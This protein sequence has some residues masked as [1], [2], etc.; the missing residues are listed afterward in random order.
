M[1][2]DV[3]DPDP[4]QGVLV[5]E[6]SDFLIRR[7]FG[8]R[9]VRQG[10]QNEIA[11][12]QPS[13]GQLTRH[14]RMSKNLTSF[15]EGG[16]LPVACAQMIDPD[17]RIDQDHGRVVGR[18]RGVTFNLASVP[19]SRANRRALSRSISALSASRTRLDFSFTPVKA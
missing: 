18:R 1:S 9:Q 11:L 8:L 4:E 3:P 13:Q 12:P 19:P 17:R 16:E 5:D 14:E 6:M 10:I 7:D 2:I 15:E